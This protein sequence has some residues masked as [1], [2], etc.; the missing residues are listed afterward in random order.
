MSLVNKDTSVLGI[1]RFRLKKGTTLPDTKFTEQEQ[2][3]IAFFV[4]KGFLVEDKVLKA[5]VA[6][7]VVE[8]APKV[9]EEAPKVVEEAIVVGASKKRRSR[10]SKVRTAPE[11]HADFNVVPTD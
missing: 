6:P 4:K 3:Q 9:V 10:K 11:V 8:E 7:K 5:K 1:G 2:R